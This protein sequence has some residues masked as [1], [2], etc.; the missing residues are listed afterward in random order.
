MVAILQMV[1]VMYIESIE[2]SNYRNYSN[3]KVEF[4]KNT[5]ILYGD[6]AQGKT[7]ILESI[8]MAATTKSHRKIRRIKIS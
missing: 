3:V 6:N 5:N 7:N 1:K 8:Y 4:G 2:L